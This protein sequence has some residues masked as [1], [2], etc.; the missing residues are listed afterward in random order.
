MFIIFDIENYRDKR[1]YLVSLPIWQVDLFRHLIM[2]HNYIIDYL[3]KIDISRY[4]F[5]Y[6]Q[7]NMATPPV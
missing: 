3:F 2:I 6:A 7:I 5:G 4:L 1:A